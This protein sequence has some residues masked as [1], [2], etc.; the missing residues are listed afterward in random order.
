MQ[1]TQRCGGKRV[2]SALAKDC[3]V[4]HAVPTGQRRHDGAAPFLGAAIFVHYRITANVVF[5]LITF[6]AVHKHHLFFTPDIQS[7]VSKM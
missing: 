2:N 5:T 6:R 3:A 7:T 4:Q 1:I